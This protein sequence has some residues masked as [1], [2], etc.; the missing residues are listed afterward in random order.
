MAMQPPAKDPEDRGAQAQRNAEARAALKEEFGLLSGADVAD[1]AGS[2]AQNRSAMADE[3]RA[4]RQVFTVEAGGQARF[5]GFQFDT[6]GR[7]RPVIAQILQVFGDRLAGWEL[8]LWFTGN[9]DWLGGLRPVDALSSDAEL[10]LDA[11]RRLRAELL[12]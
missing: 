8:A 5:P 2:H 9:N 12:E 6:H 10:V 4:H 3:W 11:A 1:A 7:P